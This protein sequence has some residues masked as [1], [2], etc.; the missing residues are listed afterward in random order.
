MRHGIQIDKLLLRD[1]TDSM[2]QVHTPAEKAFCDP[3]WNRSQ[4]F[5][6]NLKHHLETIITDRRLPN[7][8]QR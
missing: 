7:R 1:L 6:A 8:W 2:L 5:G 4:T 3:V